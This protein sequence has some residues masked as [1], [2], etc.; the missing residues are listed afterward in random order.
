MLKGAHSLLDIRRGESWRARAPD[1]KGTRPLVDEDARP[2]AFGR[3]PLARIEQ[4]KPARSPFAGE[5]VEM[6]VGH[7]TVHKLRKAKDTPLI[8]PHLFEKIVQIHTPDLLQTAIFEQRPKQS[9]R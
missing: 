8:T 3:I 5:S 7:A 1:L 9:P 6:P 2:S 4:P